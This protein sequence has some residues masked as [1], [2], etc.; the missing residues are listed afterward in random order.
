MFY[1]I[2]IFLFPSNAYAYLDPGTGAM[3]IQLIVGGI[4]AGIV[5]AK[6]Y[7]NN[8]CQYIQVMYNK[9]FKKNIDEKDIDEKNSDDYK[10]S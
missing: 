9:Y 4:A 3:I 10:K 7:W 6:V 8:L 2:L 5:M 1:F